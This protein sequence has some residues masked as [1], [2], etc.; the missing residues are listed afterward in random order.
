[1]P[2]YSFY[3]IVCKDEN[4]KDCYVGKTKNLKKRWNNHKSSCYNENSKNYNSKLYQYI[5]ENNGLDNFN[6]IEIETNEYDDKY[7]AIR[8]RYL[9]EEFNANLNFIIPSRTKKEYKKDY[10]ENN[11]EKR[12][13][14]FKE[15][16]EKNKEHIKEKRKEYYEN[17]KDKRKEQGK[18]YRDK[19]KEKERIRHKK[20]C[21]KNKEKIKKYQEIYYEN[22]K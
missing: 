14:Y 21:E 20:Y 15:W 1:M 7:S 17:H 2:I 10:Y 22:N 3:K 9:I 6:I 19:N 5:R 8:E 12:K 16:C 4:I 11:K 13:E 18:E